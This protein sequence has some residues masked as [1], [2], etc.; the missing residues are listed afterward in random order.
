MLFVIRHVLF[1]HY[2]IWRTPGERWCDMRQCRKLPGHTEEFQSKLVSHFFNKGRR[3]IGKEWNGCTLP[4]HST[5]GLPLLLLHPNVVFGSP[6]TSY[7]FLSNSKH[8]KLSASI[9]Y[10]RYSMPWSLTY[11]IDL[12]FVDMSPWH[13]N[14]H[15][16]TSNF[17][18][19]TITK[20]T[21]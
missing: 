16:P 8:K 15:H 6:M 11:D 19:A 12:G 9:R 14:L 2:D 7:M 5:P 1:F 13:D 20:C 17:K 10:G 18:W 4:L 21:C 3:L